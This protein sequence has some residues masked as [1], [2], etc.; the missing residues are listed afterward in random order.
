MREV[1]PCPTPRMP[2]PAG[3][4]F[5]WQCTCVGGCSLTLPM[6]AEGAGQ[7][8]RR[9]WHLHGQGVGQARG[10]EDLRHPAQLHSRP[11]PGLPAHLAEAP[12]GL[13]AGGHQVSVP[14]RPA[15]RGASAPEGRGLGGQP[16]SRDCPLTSQGLSPVP[17]P[18]QL[19][20]PPQVL[21]EQGG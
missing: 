13:P 8:G 7:S 4:C 18:L 12:T 1:W 16:A 9:V 3:L 5:G 15:G 20:H 17:C 19:H 10:Q 2:R 14:E 11:L 6:A 21:G